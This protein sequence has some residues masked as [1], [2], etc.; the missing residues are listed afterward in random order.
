MLHSRAPISHDLEANMSRGPTPSDLILPDEVTG[1]DTM[2][3][4]LERSMIT[5]ERSAN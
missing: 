1:Y 3:D 4:G 2:G 5:P